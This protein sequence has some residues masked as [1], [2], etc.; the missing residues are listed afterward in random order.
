MRRLLLMVSVAMALV[1]VGSLVSPLGSQDLGVLPRAITISPPSPRAGQTFTIS[2]TGCPPPNGVE[3]AVF[4]A[5]DLLGEPVAEGFTEP[6][7]DGSWELE[8]DI[9]EAG[10]YLVFADCV[11]PGTA[12]SVGAQSHG[13]LLID[14]IPFLLIVGPAQAPTPTPGP[15]PTPPP[16]SPAIPVGDFDLSGAAVPVTRT[17]RFTG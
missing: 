11:P 7:D 12:E 6:E 16:S 3:I 4:S 2:G 17:P 9:P 1:G 14:Y 8:G 5:T 13:Q 10:T 15:P